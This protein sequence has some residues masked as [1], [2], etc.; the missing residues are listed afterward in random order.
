[1][2]FRRTK[3]RST[4]EWYNPQPESI[5]EVVA[6]LRA[7]SGN[8]KS[9]VIRTKADTFRVYLY[10]RDESDIKARTSCAVGW[11]GQEGPSIT[12]TIVRAKELASEYLLRVELASER[13]G[14]L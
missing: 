9:L 11:I 14:A 1:M 7:Q 3:I 5:G 2:F 6:E 8:Y 13:D 4:R 12:D 10:K